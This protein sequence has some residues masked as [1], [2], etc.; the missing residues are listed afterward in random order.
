MLIN[1][2]QH[3]PRNIITLFHSPSSPASQRVL[4]LLKTGSAHATET[5]T[6]DQASD[7]SHHDEIQ[8]TMQ[9]F[10]LD[11]TEEEPTADQRRTI[12]EYLASQGGGKKFERPTVSRRGRK[13]LEGTREGILLI[14]DVQIVDWN[15]GKAGELQIALRSGLGA[16]SC[17]S[18]RGESVRDIE[19][20]W[21][22]SERQVMIL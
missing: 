7:H 8:K 6:E 14:P 13:R 22:I 12:G 4:T 15:N 9:D 3:K 1:S 18:R 20:A 2:S 11:V 17:I 10:D 5:A 19:D 21:T 16:N